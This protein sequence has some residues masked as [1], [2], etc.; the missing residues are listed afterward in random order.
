[1]ENIV[2]RRCNV[3]KPLSDFPPKRR[4]CRDCQNEMAKER[5]ALQKENPKPKKEINPNSFKTCLYCTKVKKTID[6]SKGR[7]HCKECMNDKLRQSKEKKKAEQNPDETKSC[8][9]CN[10]VKN[11][12]DFSIGRNK[13]KKCENEERK[14]RKAKRVEKEKD[15]KTKTC[16]HCNIEQDKS[17]FR[18][19]E[20]TCWDCQKE[21]LYKW[22]KENPDKVSAI[23]KKKRSKI[24]YQEKMNKYRKEKYHTD[25]NEK[26][27]RKYHTILRN[28]LFK[29]T[30]SKYNYVFGCSRE[31]FLHWIE[32]NM[33]LD[34]KWDDYGKTWHLDHI[35]PCSSYDLSKESEI[36]ECFSWKNTIP[37]KASDNL[38]KHNKIDDDMIQF[39][40][41]KSSKFEKKYQQKYQ[42]IKP[43]LLKQLQKKETI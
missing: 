16:K 3:E 25:I 6:F 17:K 38:V 34:I 12:F 33:S 22:R 39:Y 35:K 40:K 37:L 14:I 32:D 24:G 2:C 13:C 4:K 28:Y 11:I 1:M 31:F 5:R 36:E 15:L 43:T 42:H 19:G 29:G 26:H 10:Q 21:I 30:E 20:F 41:I 23:D 27:T 8:K 18:D 9:K 7:N